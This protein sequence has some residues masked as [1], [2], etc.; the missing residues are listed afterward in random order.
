MTAKAFE[1]MVKFGIITSSFFFIP[2][3]LMAISKA[4]VPFE[5]AIECFLF[6]FFENLFSKIFTSGPSDE[7]QPF[8]KTLLIDFISSLDT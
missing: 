5:T 4:A 1:I 3:A 7:I 6:T 2:N 8:F